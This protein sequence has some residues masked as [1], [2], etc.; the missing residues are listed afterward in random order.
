MPLTVLNVAF[1]F[2]PTSPDTVGGAEQILS[3]LDFALVRAGHRSVVVA[4]DDS[5][6]AGTL[7]PT[8]RPRHRI[9]PE[10]AAT[11]L[12]QHRENVDRAIDRYA[13]DG[14]HLHGI[15]FLQYLPRPGVPALVT[16][17]MAPECYPQELFKL[18]RPAT[19][20][21]CVSR[22]QRRACPPADNLLPEIPTGAD[23][24]QL[25]VAGRKREYLMPLGRICPE[26][27]QPVALA[28]AHQAGLP[29]LLGGQV[30]PYEQ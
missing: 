4:A 11:V 10:L 5:R 7:I 22:F 29:L 15:D 3:A 13:P 20:L 30:F 6:T 21:Q 27:N 8:T 16:L 1:P 28:A 18:T 19:F 23:V 24:D 2:A 17:H 9:T 14:V 25:A 26:K 12:R